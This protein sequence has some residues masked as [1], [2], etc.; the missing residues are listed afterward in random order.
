MLW[1]W[2]HTQLTIV[3]YLLILV[4]CS[5]LLTHITFMPEHPFK[6]YIIFMFQQVAELQVKKERTGL[7]YSNFC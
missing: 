6:L 1:V 4:T 3:P 7:H 2:A 5:N